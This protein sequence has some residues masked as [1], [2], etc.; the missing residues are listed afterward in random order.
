MTGRRRRG[1]G[2]TLTEFALILPALLL[3]LM[4]ILDFGR[5][6]YAYN[7][8]SNA[9]RMGGR[10]AIV[11]QT[12]AEIR[13]RAI[14]QATALG[15]DPTSTACP[16]S[17]ASGVCIEF[18]S[19]DLSGPCVSTLSYVGCVA[20]VTVKYSFTAITPVIG[21][22]LGTMPMTSKTSQVIESSCTTGGGV[23]CPIP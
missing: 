2:Q 14:A 23:T 22:I 11:N 12:P 15:I 18:K 4:G 6:I 19:A 5:G 13:A 17:G 8:I 10:T 20:Q 9:A 1:A 21:R 3:A 7:A 16:P